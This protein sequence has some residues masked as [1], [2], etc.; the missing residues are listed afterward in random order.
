LRDFFF[1]SVLIWKYSVLTDRCSIIQGG[2]LIIDVVG[3]T[4]CEVTSPSLCFRNVHARLCCGPISGLHFTCLSLFGLFTDCI[5][6]EA[7]VSFLTAY[8]ILH[9]LFKKKDY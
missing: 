8:V 2:A 6:S 3:K 5:K 1:F 7:M 9:I 4:E